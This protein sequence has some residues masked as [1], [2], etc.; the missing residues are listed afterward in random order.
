[1]DQSFNLPDSTD[2]LGTPLSLLAPLES[3]LRCQVCKD[4]FDNPVITSC[5]HTFCSLCIRRC[6]S[7]E[8][9][10][11]ACRSSD[12]ELKLRRNWAVQELVDAFN[13]ARPKVLGLAQAEKERLEKR[14]DDA[15]QP[16]QKKRKVSRVAEEESQVEEA[17]S[18]GRQTRSSRTRNS[19]ET[20]GASQVIPEVIEDSQDDDEYIP[21]DG[22]VACP[23]CSQKMK[24]EAVFGHLNVHTE[25]AQPP[26][27]ATFGSFMGPSQKGLSLGKPPDR[28]PAINYSI[29]KDI[30]LRKKL[31]DLGIPEWGPKQLLQRRHT[32]WMNLWNAN[33]DSKS[34][35]SKRVL[36]SELDIWERTQGGHAATQSPFVSSSNVMR[37]D[38]N[39]NEWSSNHDDDFKRL[40]ANARKKSEAQVRSTIPGAASDGLSEPAQAPT[41]QHVE[42]LPPNGARI[43]NSEGS[44]T[45]NTIDLS[46]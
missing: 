26:K 41:Q 40:I 20:P 5:S 11:P 10:C 35:K 37:K 1:M 14:E 21:E 16:A 8:G 12:Q 18:Q 42:A 30:S 2:W 13:T 36:L 29:L 46:G 19:V 9:K 32:E 22:M 4:F 24:E 23:I 39:A 34:P 15:K 28:L 43:E 27:P 33:C 31:R 44:D 6:L 25:E 7:T 38:F 45:N 3:S 17:S